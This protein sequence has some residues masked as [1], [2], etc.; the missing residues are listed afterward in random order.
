[1]HGC[2]LVFKAKSKD[3]RDYHTEMNGNVFLEWVEK[4]LVPNLPPRSCLVL[5]NAPYHNI[6]TEDSKSPTTNSRKQEMQDYLKAHNIQFDPKLT[7]PKLYD[8]I[9]VNKVDPVYK[10]DDIISQA[11]H[12]TLRL[13]PYHCNL[14]PIELVWGDIKQH[15]GI[16]NSTFKLKDVQDMVMHE[17]D[18]ITPDKWAKCVNHVIEKEEKR[19]W[20]KD[21]MQPDIEPV[22][23]ELDSSGDDSDTE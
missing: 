22:V 17:F 1:M 3:G 4:Q 6:R 7:K 5:D 11:G 20:E 10:A 18:R 16:E 8:I 13:P 21:G 23:I 19:Y 15:I 12:C 2:D 14:N 9:K